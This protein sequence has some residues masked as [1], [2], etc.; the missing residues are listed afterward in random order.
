MV[1]LGNLTGVVVLTWE[2]GARL[3]HQYQNVTDR[4]TDGQTELQ[5]CHR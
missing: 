3:Y 1:S 4:Q 2:F 5:N